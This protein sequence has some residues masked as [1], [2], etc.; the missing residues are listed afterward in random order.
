MTPW[1]IIHGFISNMKKQKYIFCLLILLWLCCQE[2]NRL[3]SVQT[4]NTRELEEHVY[5]LSSDLLRGRLAGTPGDIIASD[6]IVRQFQ[7]FKLDY[8]YGMDSY[9]KVF[10]FISAL[11][12]TA[13]NR[14]EVFFPEQ[15]LSFELKKQF[16]PLAFS[17][18]SSLRAPIAFLGYGIEL[19]EADY[20]NY[21]TLDVRG[22]IIMILRKHPW[23]NRYS[24]KTIFESFTLGYKTDL[25]Y[26]K[27][28]VGILLI[29]NPISTYE[30]EYK[31]FEDI[32]QITDNNSFYHQI[33]PVFTIKRS[34][35]EE[36]LRYIG[37]DLFELEKQLIDNPDVVFD[38]P[39]VEV[40]MECEFTEQHITSNNILG[41]ISGNDPTVSNQVIMI[42]THHDHWG[43]FSETSK[44]TTPT[45]PSTIIFPGAN[46]NA[47]GVSALIELAEAFSLIKDN[48]RHT[49]LFASF[50]GKEIGNIG[51]RN[52]LLNPVYPRNDTLVM[53]NIDQIG[54]M[55][56][57]TLYIDGTLTAAPFNQIITQVNQEKDFNFN[58][59]L[60]DSDYG[61]NRGDH[62]IF[63]QHSIPVLLI[64]TGQKSTNSYEKD[65]ADNLNYEGLNEITRFVYEVI[66]AIDQWDEK[67]EFNYESI[68][69]RHSSVVPYRTALGITAARNDSS[70]KGYVIDQV[71]LDGPAHHAGLQSED[72]ITRID[73]ATIRNPED[74]NYWL[75][76]YFP[77]DQV[78]LTVLRDDRVL[79]VSVVLE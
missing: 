25:A 22:K 39:E 36:I 71:L 35:A 10:G 20:N 56:N 33:L 65:V 26:K 59:I 34:V 23:Q 70:S 42:S 30:E 18:Q 5:Y 78:N 77:G 8:P 37:Y 62:H 51:S 29:T 31:H 13:N 9:E 28:V 27:G 63:F 1:S 11:E 38:I 46:N 19:E 57:R 76:N 40:K 50:G 16:S 4:I 17:E 67:P 68:L 6:Y 43:M 15:T 61:P 12:Y 49:L 47:S 66:L 52:Y 21:A 79:N 69:S 64:F 48:L 32:I 45:D 72:I 74:L 73:T 24:N 7:R 75:S 55:E 41:E 54:S 3:S 2:E 60:N 53:I 58:L 14:L 44:V